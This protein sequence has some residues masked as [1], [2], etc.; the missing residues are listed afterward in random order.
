MPCFLAAVLA[1]PAVAAGPPST[2]KATVRKTSSTSRDVMIVNHATKTYKGFFINSTDSPKITATSNKSC[3]L[4]TSPWTSKGKKHVDYW[5][6]CSA[7]VRAG[8]T[9]DIK[10]ATS[11]SGTI[12]VWAKINGR[13]YKIGTGG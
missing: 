9:L 4:G 12:F 2:L 7:S 5:A 1:A 11:G 10:L 8:K 13:Q 3:K 6:D